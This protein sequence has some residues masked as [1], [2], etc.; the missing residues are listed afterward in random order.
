M[1]LQNTNARD[2]MRCF[3]SDWR[4]WFFVKYWQDGFTEIQTHAM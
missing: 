4:V 2:V 1:G 3:V